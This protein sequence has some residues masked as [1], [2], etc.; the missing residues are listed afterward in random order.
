[1]ICRICEKVMDLDGDSDAYICLDCLLEK[2]KG[3]NQRLI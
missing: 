3:K 2:E 1:M